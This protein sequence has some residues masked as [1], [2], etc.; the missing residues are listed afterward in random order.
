MIT[1]IKVNWYGGQ[2][3]KYADMKLNQMLEECGDE[4]AHD[5]RNNFTDPGDWRK[6]KSKSTYKRWHW[7]SRPG[8][9]PAVDKWKLKMSIEYDTY[10]LG[11]IRRVRVGTKVKY[12]LYLELG[13]GKNL[14]ARPFIRPAFMRYT[15]RFQQKMRSTGI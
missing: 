10:K 2:F 12:G 7:S 13:I 9:P 8:L 1:N 11:R 5:I 4:L 6:Y 3:L 15:K 14:Q